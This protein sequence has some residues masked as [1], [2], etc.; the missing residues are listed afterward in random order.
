[1]GLLHVFA[2]WLLAPKYSR[3]RRAGEPPVSVVLFGLVDDEA[4]TS[5]ELLPADVAFILVLLDVHYVHVFLQKS[6]MQEDTDKDGN[7]Y[8]E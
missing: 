6:E 8:A 3:T 5:G 4:A 7:F 1:M 2:Q